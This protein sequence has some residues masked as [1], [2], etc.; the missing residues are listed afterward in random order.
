ML[1]FF[2]LVFVFGQSTRVFL[3][4]IVIRT[5]YCAPVYMFLHT[6]ESVALNYTRVILQHCLYYCKSNIANQVGIIQL[7]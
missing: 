1:Y 5:L 3:L 6:V 2:V 7:R 4:L